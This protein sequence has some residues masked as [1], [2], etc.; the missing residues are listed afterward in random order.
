MDIFVGSLSLLPYI[1]YTLVPYLY[2]NPL[3]FFTSKACYFLYREVTTFLH[4]FFF[5][6]N[7]L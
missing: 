5:L 3:K 6:Y 2:L 4:L 7:V 1:N